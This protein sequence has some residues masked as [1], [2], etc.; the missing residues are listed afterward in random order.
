MGIL[1]MPYCNAERWDFKGEQPA[2]PDCAHLTCADDE[3]RHESG[4]QHDQH[5]ACPAGR[6][7]LD[8]L[9]ASCDL[10]AGHRGDHDFGARVDPA[11]WGSGD[12]DLPTPV[13]TP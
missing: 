13:A 10:D 8:W 5:W 2:V 3:K 6:C 12:L 1:A 11:L 4:Y 9:E 7:R